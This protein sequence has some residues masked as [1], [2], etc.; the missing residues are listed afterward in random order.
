MLNIIGKS[1]Y[2]V[3]HGLDLVCARNAVEFVSKGIILVGVTI[4]LWPLWHRERPI[5]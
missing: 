4:L 5:P 3:G 1:F 2:V